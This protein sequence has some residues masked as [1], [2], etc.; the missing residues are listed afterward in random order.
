M[1]NLTEM[2][3][4]N[5]VAKRVNTFQRM[6]HNVVWILL[7]NNTNQSTSTLL[8]KEHNVK[9]YYGTHIAIQGENIS[10][11]HNA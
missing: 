7:N 4:K 8:H 3:Q 1:T 9:W 10:V 5:T 6:K 2:K 11:L